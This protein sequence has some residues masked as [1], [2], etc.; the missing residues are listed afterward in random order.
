[1]AFNVGTGVEDPAAYEYAIGVARDV[2]E[3]VA[4]KAQLLDIGGGFPKSY[5]GLSVPALDDYFCTTRSAAKALSLAENG[6]LLAEPGRALS[7]PGMSAI[8]RVLLRKSDR[9]YI[10]DGL[11]GVLWEL[12]YKAHLR[13]SFRVFQSGELLGGDTQVTRVF[14]PTCDSGD[15]LPTELELPVDIDVGD[16]IEFGSIGA[17]SL[18]GRTDFNG[19]YSNDVVLITDQDSRPP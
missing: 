18:S 15:E 6:E 10:N 14:G 16:H 12:R 8:T 19:F 3:Q 5:P 4:F 2:M 7:A 13:Y 11:Y 1:M 17:Y 9:V